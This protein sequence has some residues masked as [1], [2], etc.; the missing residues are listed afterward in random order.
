MF[1]KRKLPTPQRDVGTTGPISACGLP[2]RFLV[3]SSTESVSLQKYVSTSKQV[4]FFC[5]FGLCDVCN[6]QDER[7]ASEN[8]LEMFFP[9]LVGMI[10][11]LFGGN[12]FPGESVFP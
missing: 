12:K 2:L 11:V 1:G 6:I 8:Y 5:M 4:V 10:F 7:Q 9:H 3:V